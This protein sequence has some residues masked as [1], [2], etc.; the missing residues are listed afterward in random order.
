MSSSTPHPRSSLPAEQPDRN[1][2][3]PSSPLLRLP[4]EIR[5][6]IYS[7]LLPRAQDITF[8]PLTRKHPATGAPTPSHAVDIPGAWASRG[9]WTALLR[10]CRQLHA[11]GSD[12]LYGGNRFHFSLTSRERVWEFT[13]SPL[14][15]LVDPVS[16]TL[17]TSRGS[18]NNNNNNDDDA[19]EAITN[20][21]DALNSP[22]PR[23]LPINTLRTAGISPAALRRV[24]YLSLR[25]E[26]DLSRPEPF[27]RTAAWLRDLAA[28]LG[29]RHC[30][31]E[32]RVV[33]VTGRF[34][35]AGFPS[36]T[37]SVF[38]EFAEERREGRERWQFVLEP[39][40]ALRGVGVVELRGHVGEAFARKL[41]E[42]M[43]REE[44]DEDDAGEMDG[45]EYGV[46]RESEAVVRSRPRKFYEPV[47]DWQLEGD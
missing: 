37:R 10:T 8:Y 23:G 22:H 18:N 16:P 20:P 28:R 27:R 6:L 7:Y 26:E 21:L 11:E 42:R 13:P 30:L 15:P 46:R 38:W 3:Q 34:R 5:L 4:S 33:L 36:F 19:S 17:A 47:L 14:P 29:P 41:A 9:I 2:G 39:L 1:A 24:R 43:M 12:A 32:L 45:V 35:Y 25:I 31:Q 44:G 40:A